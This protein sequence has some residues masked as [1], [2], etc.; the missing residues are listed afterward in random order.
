MIK[1]KKYQINKTGTA[2]SFRTDKEDIGIV[3]S[4]SVLVLS[5][6]ST[7]NSNQKQPSNKYLVEKQ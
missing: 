6:N 2:I 7:G 5:V 1:Y 3:D 4:F